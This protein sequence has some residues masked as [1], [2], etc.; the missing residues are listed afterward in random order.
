MLPIQTSADVGGSGPAIAV[1]PV[2]SFEQHGR[3]LPLSTDS[4]IATA[5]AERLSLEYGLLQLPV[6]AFG[7][8]HEHIGFPG[9]VSVKATTLYAMV[10]DIVVSTTAAGIERVVIVNGHG[11]NYILQNLVQ[12]G[13]SGARRLALFPTGPDWADARNHAGLTTSNHDD[14]HGGE[15]ETSILL[16]RWP[17]VVRPVSDGSDHLADDRRNLLTIGIRGYAPRG[18]V[19][20]PSLATAGKGRLLLDS[21]TATFAEHLSIL[22]KDAE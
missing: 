7:C 12:E 11:G 16:H 19:G 5:I 1:L 2:G 17:E 4:L 3:H 14:M 13:N 8:S 6:V 22:I 21:L 9:T 10:Q 20:R 15:A 18:I